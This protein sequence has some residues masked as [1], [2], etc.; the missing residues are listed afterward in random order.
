VRYFITY[1][2]Q[3]ACELEARCDESEQGVYDFGYDGESILVGDI[4]RGLCRDL[5]AGEPTPVMAARFHNTVARIIVETCSRMG[6]ESGVGVVA[7]SGGVMQNRRPNDG[8]ICLGQAA[9]ALAKIND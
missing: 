8:G 9:C 4:F 5:D 3:A 2:G 6:K 1:E 7:L